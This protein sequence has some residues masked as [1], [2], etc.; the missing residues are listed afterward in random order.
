M[1]DDIEFLQ[2]NPS[3]RIK[4]IKGSFDDSFQGL[5]VT[6][7]VDG[8]EVS[9]EPHFSSDAESG[10]Y[11]ILELAEDDFITYISGR[12]GAVIHRLFMKT[13]KGKQFRWGK[14]TKDIGNEFEFNTCQLSASTLPCP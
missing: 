9:G 4:S 6:Y 3:A 7:D 14:G 5:V 13:D 2:A 8:E 10:T 12:A 11:S 1:F